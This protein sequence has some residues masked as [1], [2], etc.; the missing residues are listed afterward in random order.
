MAAETVQIHESADPVALLDA[1][2]RKS[3]DVPAET[4]ATL[5]LVPGVS[6]SDHRSFWRK[7]YR[8]L[9]VTD[10]AFYRYRHYHAPT[11]TPE[12]L[13]YPTMARVTQGLA[14]ALRRVS[15]QR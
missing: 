15:A 8:A 13:D 1:A 5:S 9:M 2:F 4:L 10:T 14:G 6:W 7:G 12:K 11:D 3:T